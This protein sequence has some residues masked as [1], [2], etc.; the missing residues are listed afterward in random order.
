MSGSSHIRI[1]LSTLERSIEPLV[2]KWV[3]SPSPGKEIAVSLAEEHGAIIARTRTVWLSMLRQK[4]DGKRGW[5]GDHAAI[6]DPY[7]VRCTGCGRLV[8]DRCEAVWQK[9]EGWGKR[10]EAGGLNHV[11]LRKPFY[12]FMCN[13]CMDKALAGIA[14]GQQSLC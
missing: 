5:L 8:D 11:A 10:R 14:P 2:G 4:F 7:I 3:I 9:L 12:E 6:F 13:I 1:V